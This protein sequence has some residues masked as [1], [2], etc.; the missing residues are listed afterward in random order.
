M[1]FKSAAQR[2]AVIVIILILSM[3]IGYTYQKIG[4][5]I[6]LKN[7][8]REYTEYVAKYSAE[9]GVPEYIIYGL[10]LYESD[11]KS[12][13][14]SEDGE[15]GLMQLSPE[16]FEWMLSITKEDLE[17]GILYDP[18]TNIQYGTYLLSYWYTEYNRWN[19]VLA[20]YLSDEEI[21]RDWMNNPENVDANG[22]L[23]VI[24]DERVAEDVA[25]IEE[26]LEMYKKLYY[27]NQYN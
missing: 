3:L 14:V 27:N 25:A 2:S 19:T 23:S 15:I 10:I 20:M 7:H 1:K 21:V 13:Y 8:P 18:E 6:D 22:N 16:T 9:Y 24:P 17:S 26:K 4:H 5:E 12:N 11:F